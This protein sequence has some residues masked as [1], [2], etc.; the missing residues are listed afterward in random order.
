MQVGGLL[1]IMSLTRNLLKYV[2]YLFGVEENTG[3]VEGR[4]FKK[5]VCVGERNAFGSKVEDCLGQPRVR[6]P[7]VQT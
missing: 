3:E 2:D 5:C 4:A 1:V 7:W 6:C